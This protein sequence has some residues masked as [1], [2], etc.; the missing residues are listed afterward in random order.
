MTIDAP[1]HAEQTIAHPSA[2]P[3]ASAKAAAENQGTTGQGQA[4]LDKTKVATDSMVAQNALPN[5]TI[6]MT[7]ASADAPKAGTAAASGSAG[8]DSQ[9]SAAT[10]QTGADGK[11][12]PAGATGAAADGTTPPDLTITNDGKPLT[13]DQV[14]AEAAKLEP[15]IKQFLGSAD[16]NTQKSA[17]ESY[18]NEMQNIFGHG[19]T[20]T[21]SVMN[22]I[23][24]DLKPDQSLD[25]QK[26]AIDGSP[27]LQVSNK[28]R[29]PGLSE[30]V[31]TSMGTA[32]SATG[33]E[34]LGKDG[35]GVYDT[36]FDLK[37]SVSKGV[38]ST[39]D[40][41]V[42]EA[43]AATG[44]G[45]GEVTVIGGGGGSKN[46]TPDAPS[47]PTVTVRNPD[48]SYGGTGEYYGGNDL[49]RNG[50]NPNP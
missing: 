28:D 10:T 49:F 9:G 24:T 33:M 37:T 15:M 2:Q 14:K 6:D 16:F 20:S 19:V 12:S 23:Q 35:D 31:P 39:T 8:A 3:E 27:W 46:A 30:D 1:A 44:A 18:Q 7:G 25:V 42:N 21:N 4:Q 36:Q 41:A 48:G 34:T 22:Q 32:L 50:D 17:I 5:T 13:A 40:H 45:A 26:Y 11:G 43:V 47:S 29:L 38:A